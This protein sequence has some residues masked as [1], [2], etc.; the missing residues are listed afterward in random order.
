LPITACIVALVAAARI[1]Y[2]KEVYVLV[3][4]TRHSR[5]IEILGKIAAVY[6]LAEILAAAIPT[7]CV[8]WSVHVPLPQ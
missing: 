3:L 4:A 2:Q 7:I 5:I 6:A 1:L 8:W